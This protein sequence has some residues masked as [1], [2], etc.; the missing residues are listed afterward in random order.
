MVKCDMLINLI[1]CI[2]CILYNNMMP[3]FYIECICRSMLKCF[4]VHDIV[5]KVIGSNVNIYILQR[6]DPLNMVTIN[7]PF[8][9]L[10]LLFVK[11][12]L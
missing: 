9:I 2:F 5:F 1:V 3:R 11:K 4:Q 7:N 10:L 12:K 8:I 6:V